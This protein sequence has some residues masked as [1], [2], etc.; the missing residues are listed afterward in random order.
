MSDIVGASMALCPARLAS[1]EAAQVRR[2][3][4]PLGWLLSARRPPANLL[5]RP[6]PPPAWEQGLRQAHLPGLKCQW[7]LQWCV[8]YDGRRCLLI[9]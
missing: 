9:V 1:Q 8:V 6:A 7:S 3:A 5:Q 2:P 4:Y